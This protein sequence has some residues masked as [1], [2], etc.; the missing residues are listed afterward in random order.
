M[1]HMINIA[2][3]GHNDAHYRYKREQLQLK[4]EGRGNGIK[5][6]ITNMGAVAQQLGVPPECKIFQS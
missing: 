3:E 1:S 6:V 5:T 4:I 2:E